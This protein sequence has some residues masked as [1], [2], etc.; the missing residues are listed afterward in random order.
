MAYSYDPTYGTLV[1]TAQQAAQAAVPNLPLEE[2]NKPLQMVDSKGQAII[3]P[4][5][6]YQQAVN[7]GSRLETNSEAQ[8]RDLQ[9]KYGDSGL[10]AFA[11]GTGRG[12]TFG[13][14]DLILSQFDKEGLAGR[15]EANP[16]AALAGEIAGNI[17]AMAIPGLG[18][19]K[20]GEA[21]ARVGE[22]AAGTLGSQIVTRLGGIAAKGA[23][24]G[25][26][27][28]AGHAV[29]EAA[30][31]NPDHF[32]E[33]LYS[34][35]GMG[36]LVGGIASPLLDLG[37]A[38]LGKVA[39]KVGDAAGAVGNQLKPLIPGLTQTVDPLTGEAIGGVRAAL[40][41]KV[42]DIYASIAD[43]SPLAKITKEDLVT[44][45]N[46]PE[47]RALLETPEVREELTSFAKEAPQ[48]LADFKTD[49]VGANATVRKEMKDY[50]ALS[51]SNVEGAA[52]DQA[53]QL[54]K[55]HQAIADA[56]A[57][58]QDKLSDIIAAKTGP[59]KGLL[60]DANKAIQNT[61]EKIGQDASIGSSY[62]TALENA[63]KTAAPEAFDISQGAA[64][65]LG[66]IRSVYNEGAEIAAIRRLKQ[67]IGGMAFDKQM[68]SLSVADRNASFQMK[69]LYSKLDNILKDPANVGDEF[70]KIMTTADA[71]YRNFKGLDNV[72]K[73]ITQ[74]QTVQSTGLKKAIDSLDK[75]TDNII[76][77]TQ[78]DRLVEVLQK[79][80]N[81]L[82]PAAEGAP[83]DAVGQKL[84]SDEL[85][86]NLKSIVSQKEA[87]TQLKTDIRDFLSSPESKDV[88]ALINKAQKLTGGY[89][90]A[91]QNLQK[92]QSIRQNLAGA[93]D[94]SKFEK[95]LLVKQQ[96]GKLTPEEAQKLGYLKK[97][98][99]TSTDYESKVTGQQG[100][101]T[102]ASG[103]I[104]AAGAF[105]A[106]PF[107]AIAGAA[108]LP[109]INPLGYIRILDGMKSAALKLQGEVVQTAIQ[110]V[111]STSKSVI[112]NAARIKTLDYQDEKEKL[113]Q[114]QQSLPQLQNHPI[115][116]YLPP[117]VGPSLMK[118][119]GAAVQ[120]LQQQLPQP[121]K[122][123]VSAMGD[124]YGKWTP[125]KQ[126]MQDYAEKKAVVDNP[127][128]ALEALKNGS[129]TSGQVEA[130]KAVYPDTYAQVSGAMTQLAQKMTDKGIPYNRNLV[131]SKW[132]GGPTD[133]ATAPD[134]VLRQQ[135]AYASG[136]VPGQ[137]PQGNGGGQKPTQAGLKNLDMGS[138]IG[139]SLEQTL[140]RNA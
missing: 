135:A 85:I 94:A 15:Q 21:A 93:S 86:Q 124:I 63:Y 30:L 98:S 106:G 65:D 87:S 81:I 131:L 44:R 12:A 8:Q 139:T 56:Q 54:F 69:D 73:D 17:G 32:G 100:A 13:V 62:R 91:Q 26:L 121:P 112:S 9:E 75:T 96:T 125:T 58:A 38:G 46:N 6:Q 43:I 108:S 1:D 99:Q 90:E 78:N 140:T 133:I 31:G 137:Q 79:A 10:R 95:A 14:S 11:E 18:I 55:V 116:A 138:R 77:Q 97:L 72:M 5:G 70:S 3:V 59:A 109:F 27:F 39:S 103:V 123:P 42:N 64:Q 2:M 45:L 28:G 89:S 35:V 88:N 48:V 115:M 24:E 117:Q 33:M 119:Q 128:V 102:T 37:F 122:G 82:K 83:T 126:Q 114:A 130:L 61:A 50:V 53:G 71:E 67:D 134:F 113:Q 20:A 7:T 52:A 132:F 80:Q 129:L 40:A 60:I 19:A 47:G 68:S 120:Y 16:K 23:A 49:L 127:R 76:N 110:A 107:G 136:P 66:A 105:A 74:K 92:L 29:S 36:A 34:N 104:G 118:T 4:Q 22:V 41:R 101:L 25:A 84:V 57:E 111:K 51:Q